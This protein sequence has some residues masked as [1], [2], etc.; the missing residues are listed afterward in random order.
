MK[1]FFSMI[2]IK[3]KYLKHFLKINN[4]ARK[5]YWGALLSVH[6]GAIARQ[7]DLHEPVAVHDFS[8]KILITF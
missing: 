7:Q 5:S 1:K 8:K 4:G 6:A 2:L 3:F